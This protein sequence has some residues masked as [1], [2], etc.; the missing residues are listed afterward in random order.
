M[1]SADE[2]ISSRAPAR[3]ERRRRIALTGDGYSFIALGDRWAR[4][5]QDLSDTAG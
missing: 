3:I 5:A 1:L 2:Q 4:A